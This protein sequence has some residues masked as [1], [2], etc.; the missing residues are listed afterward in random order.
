[1]SAITADEPTAPAPA[2]GKQPGRLRRS[3]DKYWY[4]WAFITPV[5]IV[6]VVIILWPLIQGVFLSFTDASEKN[7]A[8]VIGGREIPATYDIVGLK[9]YIDVLTSGTFWT[10]FARTIVWTVVNVFFHF[11]LGMILALVHQPPDQGPRALPRAA[12]R[13]VGGPRVRV[14][15][16]VAP[17]AHRQRPGEQRA[18]GHRALARSR[19]CP[20][21]TGC[22]SAASWSTSGWAC[23][24]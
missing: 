10:I 12:D 22:S 21:R 6:M 13:A 16:H 14:D 17:A 24:S 8:K 3:W 20:T 2:E 23:R 9:N 11:T 4:A 7:V 19:G 18:A 1:M 15:V 5:V